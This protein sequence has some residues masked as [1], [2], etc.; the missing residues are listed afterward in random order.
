MPVPALASHAKR[1]LCCWHSDCCLHSGCCLITQPI[2]ARANLPGAGKTF[3]VLWQIVHAI[4]NGVNLHSTNGILWLYSGM[5]MVYYVVSM[6]RCRCAHRKA[7]AG[8]D[9]RTAARATKQSNLSRV[10]PQ[11]ALLY[12]CH[13]HTSD[14]LEHMPLCP[15]S[16]QT[17]VIR[18]TTQRF[19][20]CMTSIST[21]HQQW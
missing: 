21:L 15:V 16:T 20:R 17:V 18:T 13:P 6:K 10:N 9:S 19:N 14:V 2:K 12:G 4:Y 11:A 5:Y 7:A 3:C 8:I 1:S